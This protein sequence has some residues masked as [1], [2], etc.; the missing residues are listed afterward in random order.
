MTSKRTQ[1]ASALKNSLLAVTGITGV[2][3]DEI[4]LLASD[5]QEIELP[6]IQIIDMAE[7]NVHEMRR[8]LKSWNVSL[9]LVIGPKIATN[10]VPV[11]SDVWD[12][13]EAMETKLFQDPKLSLSFVT[14][15][16]LLGTTTD[17]HI[18][19]PLFTAR[20]DLMISY[21]QMLS[22]SC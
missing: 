12:F 8:G 21:Y 5:F 3:Y 16:T 20:M 11:Q 1:I 13:L 7:D 4:K 19:K 15:M 10:Y 2:S 14:Q 9:E 6:A 18:L 22:S 17:L